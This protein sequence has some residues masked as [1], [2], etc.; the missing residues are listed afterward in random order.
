MTNGI[1]TIFMA[2]IFG[3]KK[4]KRATP[5]AKTTHNKYKSSAF[6]EEKVADSKSLKEEYCRTRIIP[7]YHELSG[8]QS[9]I[10]TETTISPIVL[11]RSSN[12]SPRSSPSEFNIHPVP[13]GQDLDRVPPRSGAVGAARPL[14]LHEKLSKARHFA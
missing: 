1:M 12:N 11:H 6:A 3:M 7:I 10:Q 4:G 8:Q 5:T 2:A 14:S 9:T 13:D